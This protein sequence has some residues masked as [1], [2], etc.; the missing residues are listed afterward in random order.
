MFD[1]FAGGAPALGLWVL[2][3]VVLGGALIYGIMRSGSLNSR[4]RA[5]LDANTRRRQ[6]EEDPQKS[7]GASR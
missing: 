4:E 6:R 7:P 2:G 1:F 3:I 5:V